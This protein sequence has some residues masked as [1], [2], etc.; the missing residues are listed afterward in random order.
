VRN[1]QVVA[2]KDNNTLLIVAT[3]PE[4]Q[5]IEQALKKLDVPARQVAMEVTIASVTLTDEL[6]FGV[7]WLFKGGAPDGRGAGG[8][9]IRSS[10]FNPGGSSNPNNTGSV[11]RRASRTSSRTRTSRRHPGD[12]A[13]ARHVT[14]TRRSS[15]IRT[16]PRSTT[17]RRRSR[18]ATRSR[19]VSRRSSAAASARRPTS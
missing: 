13:P 17:R 9:F 5:V 15:P 8:L 7:E 12:P 11:S 16:S 14:A 10:P 6:N 4:F 19:S 1:I 18:P 2:D 3:P